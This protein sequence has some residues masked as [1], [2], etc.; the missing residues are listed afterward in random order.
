MESAEALQELIADPQGD[1]E[2]AHRA[3]YEYSVD[4]GQV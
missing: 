4:F 3:T 2:I 1:I